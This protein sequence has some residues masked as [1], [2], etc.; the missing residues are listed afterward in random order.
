MLP[1]HVGVQKHRCYFSFH[2]FILLFLPCYC[3]LAFHIIVVIGGQAPKGGL[4]F[5]LWPLQLSYSFGGSSSSR[6]L[7]HAPW[8][9]PLR[10]N[11]STFGLGRSW[12]FN[13]SWTIWLRQRFGART[14]L[15]FKPMVF[16]DVIHVMFAQI[17]AHNSICDAHEEHLI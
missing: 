9:F 1:I 14:H 15:G 7:G 17:G 6:G 3:G 10:Q 2:S 12:A 4:A 11:H 8:T 16:I 5:C 13:R